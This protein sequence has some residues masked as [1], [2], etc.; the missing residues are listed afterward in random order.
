MRWKDEEGLLLVPCDLGKKTPQNN[1][2]LAFTKGEIN[3]QLHYLKK[4]KDSVEESNIV[5]VEIETPQIHLGC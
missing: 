3:R 4:K 2:S 5:S 1:T